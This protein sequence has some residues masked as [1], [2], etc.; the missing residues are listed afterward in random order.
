LVPSSAQTCDIYRV[1][2]QCGEI[3]C[4]LL[5]KKAALPLSHFVPWLRDAGLSPHTAHQCMRLAKAAA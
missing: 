1:A 4:Q 5:A 2:G 3:G